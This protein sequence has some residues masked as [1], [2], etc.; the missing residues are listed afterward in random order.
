MASFERRQSANFRFLDPEFPKLVEAASQ[1]EDSVLSDAR[2]SC[3]HARRLVELLVMWLYEHDAALRFP[4]STKLGAL[5]AEPDLLKVIPP[6]ILAKLRFIQTL[7]NRAVHRATPIRQ[8]DALQA[9]R[10]AFHCCFWLV[11]R[12]TRFGPNKTADVRFDEQAIVSGTVALTTRSPQQLQQLEAELRSRDEK[13]EDLLE[14]KSF[15]TDELEK[16]RAELAR[17]VLQNQRT[18]PKHDYAEAETRDQFIDL[19]LREAGWDP[20]FESD[21]LRAREFPVT[22]MPGSA[23][24]GRVDY[25]L[26]D[27]G[28][29]LAIIEAKRTRRDP[30]VGQ[31]QAELYANALENRFGQRPIIF[32]T[33]GYEHWLWDDRKH[34]PRRVA[35][36]YSREALQ[37]LI[38]R[39]TTATS[40][41]SLPVDKAICSRY[42]QEQA[43]RQ[44]TESFQYGRRKALVVMATGSG[45]TRMLIA[46]CDLMQR[47]NWVK[48]VLFL[49]D[50]KALVTQATNAFKAF[51]PQSSAVNLVTDKESPNS[52]VLVSTYATMMGLIDELKEDGERQFGVGHFDLV[53]IDEAH[54]S[55][56]QKYRAIFNY[57]DS[58]LVGLTATPRAEVDR[59]TYSLFD[60]A[61]GVP[62]YAYELDRAVE[63][64]Y[65]VPPRLVS[66]PLKFPLEG[67]KYDDLPDE[68]KQRWEVIDWDESGRIPEYVE[69]PAVNAWLFNEDTVDKALAHLMLAGLKVDGGERLGKTIIFAKNHKH[70]RFIQERFDANYPHLK[71]QFARVIDNEE[72]FA[73]N[74]IDK[75]SDPNN[76]QGPQIAISV[77]MLDT[78]IDIPEVVNLV[79]FKVV[80]SR[81]KFWQ[82]I[83]RGTRLRADLFGPGND[84]EFF[85]VFDYCGNFKF[86][87]EHAQSAEGTVQ[88][89]VGAKLFRER[90]SLIEA[91]NGGGEPK[92]LQSNI[93]DI[94]HGEV[95]AM[96][97]NNFIVRMH[98]KPVED[99]KNRTRWD[100]L[101]P[102]DLSVLRNEVAGLPTELQQENPAAKFFDLLICKL[103]LA[104]LRK[105]PAASG[106]IV[107]VR[108]IASRLEEM[109][110]IP[111]VAR[112]MQLI[113]EVQSD[114][115]WSGVT[116][117][118]LED[119]R[120]RLRSLV[121]FMPA[122][123]Q[124]IVVTDFTDELGE[125]AEVS[126]P[127]LSEAI[128][129]GEYKRK[130]RRFLE[131]HKDHLALKKVRYNEQLT[132]Q[133]LRELERMLFESGE[134]GNREDFARCYGNQE[135][136]GVFIRKLVGLDR[137]AAKKAFDEYL[138]TTSFN[139]R[140]IEF[141]N[142][143]IDYLT[144]NG[145]MEPELLFAHPFTNLHPQGPAGLFSDE[146][147]RK[148]VNIVKA[149][150][151]NA[152]AAA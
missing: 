85:Y 51:L 61:T 48:R 29:P 147:A 133:D 39:R 41:S 152:A 106:L 101:A 122:S 135:Q 105:D 109:E 107:Q 79:F 119:I 46:L 10:E 90:L 121:Q 137:Q 76:R 141:I 111:A 75:F 49:A 23:G 33:N 43:I 125:A 11:S 78:G 14:A 91:L 140:Q 115:F 126:I 31:H 150:K 28:K 52:R 45:K 131:D 50:R 118:M 128:D 77:D 71:G 59:D 37:R 4:Y 24:T 97:V 151:R 98:R 94:L 30:R 82:M 69:A 15:Y 81:T 62:S 66:V 142:L 146:D 145:V 87:N 112:E 56:Y 127:S 7:G 13:I 6:E 96:N 2:A 108:E 92:S 20:D 138:E 110:R 120:K 17:A 55:V 44:V 57:F 117:P 80:R 21:S 129:R 148:I 88:E 60:L 95:A 134:I 25:V 149:I 123:G 32:Y 132:A 74:L 84:K 73:Q 34:P 1:M 93:L 70:A 27:E 143:V 26:W 12:Y 19:L 86:F 89:S 103:Q 16:L 5:L 35:G 40:L 144:Q 54:R 53:V 64:G 100:H 3:F 99:F 58:Y 18:T 36:F 83:G 9:A 8:Y 68:E 65:L 104:I 42:Y 63:D 38:Q 102:A 116:L 22:G 67:I 113:Q 114:S 124:R 139:S 136:L 47:C 72:P 130:F